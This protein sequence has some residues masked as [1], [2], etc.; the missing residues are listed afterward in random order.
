[1]VSVSAGDGN[2]LHVTGNE[3]GAVFTSRDS[4]W[5]Y[6]LQCILLLYIGTMLVVAL[7]IDSILWM[8]LLIDILAYV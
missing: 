3:G 8:I 5:H 2:S 7:T 1:M 4:T 6:L